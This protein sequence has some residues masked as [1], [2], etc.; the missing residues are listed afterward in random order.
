M[1]G[2]NSLEIEIH[3]LFQE[4]TSTE[5]VCREL[6]SK[7]EKNEV[8]SPSEIE[9]LSH[10]LITCGQLGLLRELYIKVVQRS[11]TSV[12]PVGFFIEAIEK[13]NKKIT[14]E[15]VDICEAI[16]EKQPFNSTA[17]KSQT[18]RSFSQFAL[19]QSLEIQKNFNNLRLIEKT[20]LIELLNHYRN[21][22][23]QEQEEATLQKLLKLYPQ[24]LEI[25]LLKQAHLEKKADVI[26]DHIIAKKNIAKPRFSVEL[27]DLG[28]DF[29]SQ[30]KKHLL[31]IA[32]ELQKINPGQLYN[33]AVLCFQSELY[34]TCLDILKIAPES[35]SQ[36]WLMAEALLAHRRFIDLLQLLEQIEQSPYYNADATFGIIYMQAQAYHGLGQIEKAIHLMESLL[37]VKTIYR[38]AE[39]LLAEWK[40]EIKETL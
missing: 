37:Q 16:L 7:Y 9:G 31:Q 19:K 20:K 28:V 24:D 4:G 3:R 17:L 21:T 29:V 23:L 2:T 26:L 6:V 35:D 13:Q 38:S 40:Q 5:F 33:L 30:T 36:Q 34:E 39:A 32:S 27:T 18:I 25:G 22:E 8:L 10:F 1:A 14:N 11:K 15:L 12:F